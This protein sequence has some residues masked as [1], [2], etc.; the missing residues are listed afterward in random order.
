MLFFRHKKKTESE[1]ITAVVESMPG[2]FFGGVNPVVQFKDK[3]SIINRPA[4]PLSIPEKKALDSATATG[5]GKKLHP[6]NLLLNKKFIFLS[7]SVLFGIFVVGAAGYYFWPYIFAKKSPTSTVP[8][9]NAVTIPN[10]VT[11]ALV[12]DTTTV[13]TEIIPED[14]PPV[15]VAPVLSFADTKIAYP[16]ALL[17]DSADFD[18]DDITD[19]AEELF[20][21]DPAV[22]DSDGD[23]YEDGHELY[24]L[25][26]PIRSEPNRLAESGLVTEYINPVFGYK[27]DYPINWAVGN[28]DEQGRDVLF[29][30]LT[31]ENIEARVYDLTAGQ[32]L[33]DWMANFAPTETVQSLVDFTTAF[34]DTGMRRSDYLVYYFVRSNRVYVLVYHAAIDSDVINYRSVIKM[35]ARGFRPSGEG[36]AELTPPII[37]ESVATS[38]LAPIGESNV[39]SSGA[40]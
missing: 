15:E 40:L 37:E 38:D 7:A 9:Q 25:Y 4:S 11:P 19:V 3:P 24:N 14:L 23:K 22:P 10:P 32:T 29:S 30:T 35:M 21:T 20:K 27:L 16:S 17:S 18:G 34:K 36:Q 2:E 1:P 33:T 26:D 12:I 6:V 31:G 28:V 13:S 5:A 8:A 39:V